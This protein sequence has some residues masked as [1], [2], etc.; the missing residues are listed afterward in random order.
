[1][2]YKVGTIEGKGVGGNVGCDV[3]D[4]LGEMVGA[5]LG[6]MVSVG[7]KVGAAEGEI[8]AVPIEFPVVTSNTLM[9]FVADQALISAGRSPQSKFE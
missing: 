8:Q 5:G 2:G 9:L 4:R 1:V 7:D 6:F 3:G